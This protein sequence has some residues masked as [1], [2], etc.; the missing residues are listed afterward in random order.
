VLEKIFDEF[1]EHT[2]GGP[3]NPPEGGLKDQ[4]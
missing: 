4:V 3:L 1:I 2:M